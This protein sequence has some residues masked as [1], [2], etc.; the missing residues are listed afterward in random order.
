MVAVSANAYLLAFAKVKVS[1]RGVSEATH[2]GNQV[3]E[4]LRTRQYHQIQNGEKHLD[5]AYHCNWDV[6]ELGNMKKVDVTI[7]WPL[8]SRDHTVSLSTIIAQ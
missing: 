6:Q 8:D 2:A 4:E 3:L 1:V 7:A 5:D